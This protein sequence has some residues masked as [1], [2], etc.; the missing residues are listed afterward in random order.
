MPDKT[1]W[2][3]VSKSVNGV[4]YLFV[5]RVFRSVKMDGVRV[6][7]VLKEFNITHHEIK[8][9]DESIPKMMI[10][11][12][13]MFVAYN[14]YT[15]S[16]LCTGIK[17]CADES[18]RNEKEYV[19]EWYNELVSVGHCGKQP[20]MKSSYGA[21]PNKV[22]AL[23]GSTTTPAHGVAQVTEMKEEDKSEEKRL[24]DVPI[25]RDSSKVFPIDLLGLSPM[26]QVEF[27]IDLILGVVPVAR[28][29]YRLDPSE[30]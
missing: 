11:C 24:E 9:H 4:Y 10:S 30:M 26:R 25:V 2:V 6:Q 1:A 28:S 15:E 20:G 5:V 12:S 19:S 18:S 8:R 7:D 16:V 29:P 3:I 17:S 22:S 23:R 21:I 27:Q 13:R 14:S